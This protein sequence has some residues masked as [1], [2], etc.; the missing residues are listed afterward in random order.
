MANKAYWEGFYAKGVAPQE[1]STFAESVVSIIPKDG[2]L[3]EFG[4]GNGR[5]AFYF[6]KHSIPVVAVDLCEIS[7]GNLNKKVDRDGNP[8]FA[9]GDFTSLPTPFQD[10]N[11]ATV[12]SRFTLHAI[13][14]E[15]ASRALGWAYN[16][17]R[18]GGLLLI[19]VRS[20]LDPLCGQGTPVPGERD[21]WM[22]THYRRFVRKD[23]LVAELERL[24]FAIENLVEADNLAVYK[25]DNPVVI[26]VHARKS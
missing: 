20:V 25:D 15:E 22:T 17:L 2:P 18:P 16:N 19:E 26:R 14:A 6:A 1:S 23:E 3:L 24:G 7:I 12:Y 8:R 4:C 9:A 21:A 11:F 5:D 10:S 13:K